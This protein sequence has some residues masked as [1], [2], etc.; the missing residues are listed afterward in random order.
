MDKFKRR[1]EFI[2]RRT[3]AYKKVMQDHP[4]GITKDN[5]EQIKKEL[6]REE[7]EEHPD[8]K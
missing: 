2:E 6:H 1:Q 8:E 5:L 3:K 7:N 4:E